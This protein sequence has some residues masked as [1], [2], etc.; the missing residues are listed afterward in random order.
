MTTGNKFAMLTRWL[1]EEPAIGR[2]TPEQVVVLAAST[3]GIETTVLY[4]RK[5]Q[6]F[7]RR[8]HRGC[9]HALPDKVQRCIEYMEETGITSS[10]ELRRHL[11]VGDIIVRQAATFL[12]MEGVGLFDHPE[13]YR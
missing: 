2:L 9:F 7:A 11:Q 3:L 1:Y 4:I 6:P 12:E 5:V 10:K 8:L 13:A